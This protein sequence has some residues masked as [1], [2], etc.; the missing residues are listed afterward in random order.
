[1]EN[2]MKMIAEMVRGRR[3]ARGWTVA[4]LAEEVGCSKAYVSGIENCRLENPPSAKLVAEIERVLGIGAGEM[5][6]LAEWQT[7]PRAVRDDFRKMEE[8]LRKL[9]GGKDTR[10]D[11]ADLI[12]G[13]APGM[14]GERRADGALSLDALYRS[15][16]LHKFAG[17]EAGHGGSERPAVARGGGRET[18]L[19]REAERGVQRETDCDEE[20]NAVMMERTVLRG[21]VPLINKV[22]A[23]IPAEFTD[24]DYPAQV[25]DEYVPCMGVQDPEAFAARVLGESMMPE[26]REGDVI[27]FSPGRAVMDGSDCYVRL[28]PDHQSTFKRIFFEAGDRVRLQP[29]NPAF[30]AKVVG[31]EEIDGLYAAVMRMTPIGGR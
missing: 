12:P 19:K 15:G 18:F 2:S 1:M 26:Y 21:V 13:L 10:G 29:L 30:K 9:T 8:E 24:Y 23:G 17:S 4:R 3:R 14:N 25:A 31:R 5:M 11:S 28:L 27:V 7:T 6:K 20:R 22:A 16:A